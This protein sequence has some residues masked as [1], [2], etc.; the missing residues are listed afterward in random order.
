MRERRDTVSSWVLSL[1]KAYGRV[2]EEAHKK[3]AALAVKYLSVSVLVFGS[4]RSALRGGE[5]RWG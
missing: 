3:L 1:A 5:W 2:R 4:E